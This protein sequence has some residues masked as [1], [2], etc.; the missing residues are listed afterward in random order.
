[1]V[2]YL[3]LFSLLTLVT[4]APSS[5]GYLSV[6]FTKHTTKE[7]S[8]SH[9]KFEGVRHLWSNISALRKRQ[10]DVTLTSQNYVFYSA[11]ITLGTPAQKFTVLIDTGSSD[12]WVYSK[13]NTKDCSNGY[14]DATGQYDASFSSSY[15]FI[16]NDFSIQYVSGSAA[17]DWVTDTITIGGA[18]VSDFQFASAVDAP[19]G[20][21]VFGIGLASGEA[22]KV[23]YDNF[24][25][26]LQKAGIISRNVYSLYLDSI[27]AATGSVLFGA[28]DSSKYSGNLETLELTSPNAFQ[29]AYGDISVGGE[30]VSSGG[31]AILDSGTSFSYIP[32]AAFSGLQKKLNLGKLEPNTQL[33]TID[34][35]AAAF[36]VDFKFGASTISVPSSQLVMPLKNFGLNSTECVFGIV[37]TKY[38]SGYVLLGDTFLRSAYVVYDLD[39]K[40]IGIAPAK[41]GSGSSIQRV[42]GSL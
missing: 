31:N 16:S 40:L 37:S 41:Y 22:A 33:Y 25:V 29:V 8:S 6:P 32:E 5:Q 24:P 11:D 36:N 7:P 18:S 19:G 20:V 42:T 35:N 23:K 30:S 3:S 34:C 27:D 21:G 1:M 9:A 13:N 14:C 26:M 17:G 4:A 12:L 10:T 28:L 15:K 2:S 39:N 38:S